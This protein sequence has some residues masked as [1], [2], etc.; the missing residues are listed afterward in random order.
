MFVELQT[1]D[2]DAF[3][4]ATRCMTEKFT[5]PCDDLFIFVSFCFLTVF[6]FMSFRS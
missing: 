1:K 3:E 6:S 5:I 2:L 4:G